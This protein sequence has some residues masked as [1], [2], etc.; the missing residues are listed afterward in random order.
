MVANPQ[1]SP[2]S[3]RPLTR[4]PRWHGS[5]AGEWSSRPP[6]CAASAANSA[7]SARATAFAAH[8]GSVK[9]L[10][11]TRCGIRMS[12]TAIQLAISRPQ[13]CKYITRIV[14]SDPIDLARPVPPQATT[15]HSTTSPPAR[16]GTSPTHRNKRRNN[17]H[18]GAAAGHRNLCTHRSTGKRRSA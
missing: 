3:G 12:R 9:H 1:I 13:Q 18:A 2:C 7:A 11:G 10:A 4:S 17:H 16:E 8:F 6:T 14:A 5:D 15:C